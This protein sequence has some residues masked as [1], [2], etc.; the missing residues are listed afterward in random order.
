MLSYL[1]GRDQGAPF[2]PEIRSAEGA[3][4]LGRLAARLR[5]AMAGYPCPPDARWQ[6]ATGA[7]G[8]GQ[9]MQHGDLGPWNLLWG[10][11]GKIIGVLDWDLAEPGAARYDTGYL[12]W[13]TVPFMDDA[14]ARARGFPE[15]PP[16]RAR[17]EAFARGTG[18][19]PGE[20]LSAAL[21]A[22]REYA[23][24]VVSR[25]G[26]PWTAFR[27]LGFHRNAAADSEWTR[28]HFRGDIAS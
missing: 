16:R 1:A 10:D 4:R 17:L 12:A 28:I 19:P 14:R 13:F 11:D 15:P 25:T 21:G 2:I 8:P 5:D 7:P 23:R 3:E 22:Q 26:E 6:S 20:V 9:A 27:A 18:L 24:R